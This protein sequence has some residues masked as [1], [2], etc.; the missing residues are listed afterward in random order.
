MSRSFTLKI[1][2][3]VIAE[4]ARE[5]S[6]KCLI[7][8]AIHA[9]GGRYPAV[10]K[11]VISFNYHGTRYTYPTPAKAAMELVRFDEG[12]EIAPFVISLSG[13]SA[14]E[15]PVHYV[16]KVVKRTQAKLPNGARRK[17][18]HSGRTRIHRGIRRANGLR[19]IEV[20]DASGQ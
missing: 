18:R 17:R 16:K 11:E 8:M 12:E 9:V 13:H 10:S 2:Q 4:A 20:K 3:A 5:D 15:R 6:A 19:V 7:A 1:T 14:S